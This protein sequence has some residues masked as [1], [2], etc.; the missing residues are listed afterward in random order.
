[1]SPL[2]MLLGSVLFGLA[3]AH[4]LGADFSGTWRVDLRTPLER[5]QKAE[6]G[7]A[8]FDLV[9]TGDRITGSH[10]FAT[11]GCGRLNEGGAGTVSGVVMGLKA[12]LIVTSGRNGAIQ[13]GVATLDGDELQWISRETIRESDTP[14]DSPLILGKGILRRASAVHLSQP[15]SSLQRDRER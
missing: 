8:Q 13:L 15:N 7:T 6:C 2:R 11:V 9:Q 4:A 3:S 1:M 12:V 10:S 14:G 5:E